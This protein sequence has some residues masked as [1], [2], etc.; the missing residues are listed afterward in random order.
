[1]TATQMGALN[2]EI[3]RNLGVIAQDENMLQRVAKYLRRVVSDL[4][5]DPTAMT[6]DE[7][8]ARVDKSKEQIA[9]GE[10]TTFTNMEDMN[11]W[12]NSL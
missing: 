5:S 1:M 11:R 10:C 9:R 3:L 8:F 4:K 7:F 12:L 2:A 6:R